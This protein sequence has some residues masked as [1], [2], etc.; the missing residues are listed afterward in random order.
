MSIR[1]RAK[2]FLLATAILLFGCVNMKPY[3]A[4]NAYMDEGRPDKAEAIVDSMLNAKLYKYGKAR[5]RG[6]D[7]DTSVGFELAHWAM[8]YRLCGA[9][10]KSEYNDSLAAVCLGRGYKSKRHPEYLSARHDQAYVMLLRGKRTEALATMKEVRDV[11]MSAPEAGKPEV[12]LHDLYEFYL[13]AGDM[14][15]VKRV[16]QRGLAHTQPMYRPDPKEGFEAIIGS[17]D[18]WHF[19][20][21]KKEHL[22]DFSMYLQHAMMYDHALPDPIW[23][24]HYLL[25]DKA[26]N[27]WYDSSPRAKNNTDIG[28]ALKIAGTGRS[29]RA[30][31]ITNRAYHD[32]GRITGLSTVDYAV[33]AT[34]Y[35]SIHVDYLMNNCVEAP[36][37]YL[38]SIY[39]ADCHK[40]NGEDR[41]A[42]LQYLGCQCGQALL[43]TYA[44]V[45]D[46]AAVSMS[47]AKAAWRALR[48]EHRRVEQFEGR[49]ATYAGT[50]FEVSLAQGELQRCDSIL[51]VA[52]SA[53]L[54]TGAQ[55]R[56]ILFME[57]K[58]AIQ[59]NDHAAAATALEP[60]REFV[61][62]YRRMGTMPFSVRNSRDMLGA[63]ESADALELTALLGMG[64]QE[65]RIRSIL[66]SRKLNVVR[67]QMDAFKANR[68][69]Y[70]SPGFGQT[71]AQWQQLRQE[72]SDIVTDPRATP[73]MRDR[74]RQLEDTLYIKEM[75]LS[76]LHRD[77]NADLKKNAQ[78]ALDEYSVEAA[79]GPT[80]AVLDI[81]RVHVYDTGR[82]NYM[83]VYLLMVRRKEGPPTVVRVDDADRIDHL[84]SMVNELHTA[85]KNS[86]QVIKDLSEALV[87]PLKVA[88]SNVQ[89][90]YVC[91]DGGLSLLNWA[92]LWDGN[93]RLC[94]TR[95]LHHVHG[96]QALRWEEITGYFPHVEEAAFFGDPVFFSTGPG[97]TASA[98]PMDALTTT[99]HRD[100]E[101]GRGLEAL[102]N[103]RAEVEVAARIVK[104]APLTDV[105]QRNVKTFLGSDASESQFKQAGKVNLLHIATHGYF[106]Q[107]QAD[108]MRMYRLSDTLSSI[109]RD[110]MLMSGLLLSGSGDHLQGIGGKKTENGLVSAAEIADLDLSEAE[111]VVLSAC[112]SGQGNVATADGV[113]GLQRGFFIAGAKAVMVSFWKV[114]DT[115]T[116]MFMKEFYK[117]WTGRE[118][119]ADEAL[120]S[121]QLHFMAK[122][123]YASPRY[124]A[125]FAIISR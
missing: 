109:A 101:D 124:W 82:K 12:D 69:G 21:V 71:F 91:G 93:K 60:V 36:F 107:D 85:G 95:K 92:F 34:N 56:K 17:P 18:L 15:E 106:E 16:V 58:L 103:T 52:K 63:Y 1:T 44:G 105:H 80:A 112:L 86:D 121:T 2:W 89:R 114:D 78:K 22:Y 7:P 90:L 98:E 27:D 79:L 14:G 10:A 5:G 75:T 53:P 68:R 96:M 57:A 100:F 42:I 23:T 118:P 45:L 46:S 94:A 88:L 108:L 6:A 113:D 24:E 123:E 35:A 99:R 11:L 3:N 50:L 77:W 48:M 55:K 74:A 25:V 47:R 19:H 59:R 31:E 4:F 13:R 9:Y 70:A 122:P 39:T 116:A 67:E 33:G 110:P 102:P 37:A 64:G 38:D 8:F 65:F 83:P 41:D 125:S 87:L 43:R 32:M 30:L 66:D 28:Y 40:L 104:E 49:Y 62:E 54:T 117:R 73:R 29:T 115:F 111:L 120:R 72:L 84:V 61:D 76:V 51:R 97:T 81:H 119:I 26:L 20:K